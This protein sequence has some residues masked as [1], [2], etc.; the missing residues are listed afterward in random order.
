MR[1]GAEAVG[2]DIVC[3]RRRHHG[4]ASAQGDAQRLL[5]PHCGRQCERPSAAE[6]LLQRRQAELGLLGQRL[7]GDPAPGELLTDG[8]RNLAALLVRKLLVGEFVLRLHRGPAPGQHPSRADK[9]AQNRTWP[10][11]RRPAGP[12][13]AEHCRSFCS[14]NRAVPADAQSQQTSSGAGQ[15]DTHDTTDSNEHPWL[16]RLIVVG[17]FLLAQGIAVMLVAF[18]ALLVSLEPGWSATT[19]QASL[20]QPGDAKSGT[21]LLKE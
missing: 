15:M 19:E 7:P 8:L 2:R 3:G 6:H 11:R 12:A 17:L 5:Q 4:G 1:I 16:G 21:L 10:S 14:R 9:P 18:V 13:V 20:L